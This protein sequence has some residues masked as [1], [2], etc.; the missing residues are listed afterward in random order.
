MVKEEKRVIACTPENAAHMREVIKQWPAL[1]G[2]VSGLQAQ[3]LFPG[4]RDL[5]ITL[6]GSAEVV[7]KGLH[8]LTGENGML[9]A[10]ASTQGAGEVPCN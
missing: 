2:L 1:H 9:A 8:A 10:S 4:L 7:D 6:S 3:G 5:Q